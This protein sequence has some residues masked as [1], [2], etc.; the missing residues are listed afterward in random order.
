MEIVVE[1]LP[2]VL[3]NFGLPWVN[4][5]FAVLHTVKVTDP[6]EDRSACSRVIS[7]LV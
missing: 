2:R 1:C 5:D 4:Y 7:D 3:G 6:L